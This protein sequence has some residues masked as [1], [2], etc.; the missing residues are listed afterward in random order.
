MIRSPRTTTTTTATTAAPKLHLG[1]LNE[2][3]EI[4]VKDA[5]L[6]ARPVGQDDQLTLTDSGILNAD[7]NHNGGP[8]T[9]NIVLLLRYI[10]KL[11]TSFI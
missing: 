1:D 9:D 5:V 3:D 2:D 7:V 8:D 4:D 11:I 10:A 6:L